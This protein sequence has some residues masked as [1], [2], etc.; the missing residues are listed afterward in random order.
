MNK[1]FNL[2]WTQNLI[3]QAALTDGFLQRK[4]ELVELLLREL[5]KCNVLSF[6]SNEKIVSFKFVGPEAW[7]FKKSVNISGEEADLFIDLMQNDSIGSIEIRY[8]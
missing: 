2:E 8:R 5:T 4:P 1:T 7:H 6:D 3:K